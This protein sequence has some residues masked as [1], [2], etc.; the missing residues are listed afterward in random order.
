MNNNFFMKAILHRLV[1]ERI[2]FAKIAKVFK[3]SIIHHINKSQYSV[4]PSLTFMCLKRLL[5]LY[6][7]FTKYLHIF[8]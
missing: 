6:Y 8:I 3:L 5:V 2:Y 4:E 7:T 1:E